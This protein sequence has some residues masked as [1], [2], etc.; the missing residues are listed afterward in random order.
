ML[1]G[2]LVGKGP[3]PAQVRHRS[4]TACFAIQ[5]CSVY[6]SDAT[7]AATCI[8]DHKCCCNAVKAGTVR[9]GCCTSLL[10]MLLVLCV[11]LAGKAF[12]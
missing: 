7:F 10:P 3:N 6:I 2:D 1:V 9:H 4:A 8:L 11:E 5:A 12:S